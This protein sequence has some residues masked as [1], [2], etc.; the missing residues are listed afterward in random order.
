MIAVGIALLSVAN[1]LHILPR[2][3]IPRSAIFQ[4][5]LFHIYAALL[6][7]TTAGFCEEVIFRGFMM[8]EF[9][10]MGH[11]K[12]VQVVVPGLF[13]GLAH[14]AFLEHGIRVAVGI[15]TPTA[16]MGMIWGIA[17]LA[18]R[19][20]LLPCMVAHFLNDSTALPW[21]LFFMVSQKIQ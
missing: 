15:M 18:G 5:T 9:A 17:Y 21:I 12:V 11:G 4:P 8:T 20:S 7:G 10:R 14:L 1:G 2:L 19:R 13:F 3:G 6:I 16:I